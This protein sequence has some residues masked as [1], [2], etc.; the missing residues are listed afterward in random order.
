MTKDQKYRSNIVLTILFISGIFAFVSDD[1]YH[2]LFDNPQEIRYNCDMLIG[3]W[4]PD[5][6]KNIIDECRKM[7]EENA[8]TY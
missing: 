1:D 3:S 2:K 6:P 8:K 7:K 5:V 4:H